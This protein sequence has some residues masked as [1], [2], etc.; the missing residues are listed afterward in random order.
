[1]YNAQ[2]M[3]RKNSWNKIA[4]VIMRLFVVAVFA[5]LFSS[6]IKED[7]DKCPCYLSAAHE[8]FLWN[9]Y[10]GKLRIYA[11]GS[12]G[13]CF[14]D[15]F[16]KSE[17][18]NDEAMIGVTRGLVDVVCAGGINNMSAGLDHVLRIPVGKQ[19]DSLFMLYDRVDAVHERA[20]IFGEITKQYANIRLSFNASE[21]FKGSYAVRVKSNVSAV[22]MFTMEPVKGEFDYVPSNAKKDKFNFNLPRQLDKSMYIELYGCDKVI[23]NEGNI[24]KDFVL[25][26]T[27][28]LGKYLV[29]E[30]GYNWSAKSLSDIEIILDFSSADMSI[31]VEKWELVSLDVKF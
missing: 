17:L 1:M 27:F 19:C 4:N 18:T 16:T 13:L 28:P 29:E 24:S 12:S 10:L 15:N 25:L 8:G 21:N 9:S 30:A 2:E 5:I 26:T 14:D 7:R 3:T 6:C 11:Y 20:Y 22:D 31:T 23:Y